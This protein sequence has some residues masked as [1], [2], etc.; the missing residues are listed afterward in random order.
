VV[1]VR[2]VG[3]STDLREFTITD[4]GIEIGSKPEQ[5][6]SLLSGNTHQRDLKK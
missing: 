3:H 5:Y 1:K 2:G 4:K 6:N